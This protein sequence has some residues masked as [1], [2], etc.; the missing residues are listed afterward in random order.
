MTIP[1]NIP[2]LLIASIE[3]SEQVGVNLQLLGRRGEK[4]Y[5]YNLI[6]AIKSVF[7][8]VKPGK[9]SG[10]AH[11]QIRKFGL[12]RGASCYDYKVILQDAAFQLLSEDFPQSPFNLVTN[13][14]LPDFSAYSK[15][16]PAVGQSVWQHVNNKKF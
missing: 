8:F 5:L 16:E 2:Y 13:S 3:Y 14:S 1:F 6:N 15:P 10:Y 7:I 11:L 4:R 9:H 12:C